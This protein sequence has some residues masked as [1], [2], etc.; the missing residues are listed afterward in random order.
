MLPTSLFKEAG[1]NM[2]ISLV[3]KIDCRFKVRRDLTGHIGFFQGKGVLTFNDV[4]VFIVNN[5]TG[6]K[7]VGEISQLL[8]EIFPEVLDPES[9]VDLIVTT[10]LESGFL[11]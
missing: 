8:G 10:L 7:S 9:E 11:K 6:E 1:D 5:M 2:D 4:G 3:P